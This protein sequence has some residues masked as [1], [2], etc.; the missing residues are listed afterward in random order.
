MTPSVPP[1]IITGMMASPSRPSVR[2][3]ALAAP[4]ITRIAKGMKNSPKFSSTSLKTGSAN[5]NCS[6]AGWLS[7]AAV[8]ATAAIRMPASIRT[9]PGT[10]LV[11]CFDT[12]A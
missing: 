6:S 1:A 8:A 9:R 4:T 7:E 3:T 2:F 11:F 10:P 12:L 5:W